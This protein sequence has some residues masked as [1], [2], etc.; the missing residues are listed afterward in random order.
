MAYTGLRAGTGL[1][2][3]RQAA[4][5][6]APQCVVGPIVAGASP[7]D[8]NKVRTIIAGQLAKDEA[9]ISGATTFKELDADS[10][11]TVEIMMALEE[12]FGVELDEESAGS[13]TTV[14]EAADLISS[15]ASKA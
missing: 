4:L 13:I 7:E 15:V 10:L 12:A 14:Q 11:D 2:S 5:Y 1:F 6:L 3:K 8:L 9:S